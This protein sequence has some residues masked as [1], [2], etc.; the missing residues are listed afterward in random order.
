MV[1]IFKIHKTIIRYFL[2]SVSKLW[3]FYNDKWQNVFHSRSCLYTEVIN[4]ILTNFF[5]IYKNLTQRHVFFEKSSHLRINVTYALF[6][7]SPSWTVA[8]TPFFPSQCVS[9]FHQISWLFYA[10]FLD[11]GIG[12][13]HDL[14]NLRMPR[15]STFGG[16]FAPKMRFCQKGVCT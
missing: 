16:H 1:E 8:L 4:F 2:S 9:R 3:R 6:P 12:F 5:I 11:S 14:K 10:E 7:K 13:I 15:I